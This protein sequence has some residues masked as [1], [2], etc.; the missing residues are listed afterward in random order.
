MNSFEI[1]W[2]SIKDH[3]FDPDFGGVNWNE[4]YNRYGSLVS[5]IEDGPEFYD[6]ANRMLFELNASN[7]IVVLQDDRTFYGSSVL[8]MSEGSVGIEVR[9][10]QDEAVISR[11]EPGSIGEQ[12]KM[13]PGF[14]ILSIDG[15]NVQD[16][17]KKEDSRPKPPF[18]DHSRRYNITN[19]ILGCL[20]GLPDT[21]MSLT[22]RGQDNE[23]REVEMARQAR[24]YDFV[25]YFGQFLLELAAHLGVHV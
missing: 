23:I 16:I 9:L 15:A 17:I 13:K 11:V 1:I 2:Q 5:D 3:Y 7:T 22:Y 14:Q 21:S 6:L 8:S 25:A 12:E 19:E 20:C 18:N 24:A 4:A 10:I